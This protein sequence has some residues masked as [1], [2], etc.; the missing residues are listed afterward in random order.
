MLKIFLIPAKNH[1]KIPRLQLH[2]PKYS[3]EAAAVV[4]QSGKQGEQY[5]VGYLFEEERG[6]SGE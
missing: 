6:K 2:A 3:R 4:Q 5:M 1:K